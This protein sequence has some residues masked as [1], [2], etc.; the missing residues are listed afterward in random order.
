MAGKIKNLIY[1]IVFTSIL[2]FLKFLII[3]KI[4][5]STSK[6]SEIWFT[7]GLLLIIL[8][9]LITE[10]YFTK[11]LDV[12]VNVI[13]LFIVLLTLD[14]ATKFLLYGP[15]L[16]YASLVATIALI[17]FILVD[18]E[19]DPNVASQKIA[20]SANV[21]SGFLGSSR[22]LFSIVFILSIF[23]YFIISLKNNLLINNEQ[24][25]VLSLI[26]FWGMVIL[27]EPID[28]K[29]INPL[30]EK[31]SNK[32]KP[33]LVGK[34]IKRLNP[35]IIH[36][37]QFPGSPKLKTGDIAAIDDI[38][39]SHV[40]KSVIYSIFISELEADNKKYLQF[41]CLNSMDI[42]IE[43]QS[44]IYKNDAPKEIT[45]LE[46]YKDRDNIIGFI[47]TDSN[48]D[49]IKVRMIDGIDESKKLSEG[50]LISVNFYGNSTKYQ[51]IN[52]ETNSENID[53]QSR[54]G[55]KII[56]AQQI[57]CW[58]KDKQ[59]FV[60]VGWVP[61]VN[62]PVFIE[63][64]TEEIKLTNDSCYKVGVIPRS[65][66]PI[67]IDLEESVSHHIAIIG[68]TGTGKSRMAANILE[69][70]AS[71]GYKVVILEVD[72]KH[73]QSLTTYITKE[74]VEEQNSDTFDIS[75]S[76]KNVIS[77]NWQFSDK[78]MAA[79]TLNLSDIT[80]SIIE[81]IINY[82]IKTEDQKICIAMEEAY[83]FIPESTFGKQDFGQPKVSRISQMVLKCR[84]HNIGFLIITQRTALVTKTILYQ[85]HTIIALQSFDET[86]KTFMG[87]YISQKYLD[88]MSILPRFR[89]I[90]VGKGSSCDK[91]VIVN[92]YNKKLK[93]KE[94]N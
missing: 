26:I 54:E 22:M 62:S 64:S 58:Q 77:I 34:I 57:G 53:G 20:G 33:K 59:T 27:I 94:Q 17:S 52:V 50:D 9:T 39:N 18:Q 71:S 87:A 75:K 44:Y 66:Y 82:Q 51:I 28:R 16:V 15:L 49:V 91:P 70:M 23:S 67:F 37:E 6:D 80:A 47:D 36:V 5:I 85:C 4:F 3:D 81:N 84:K 72:R 79:G 60:D 30:I 11:P 35:N 24:V 74:L 1:L 32:S 8:G 83:D 93:E 45:E 42:N 65:Q 38:K 89:A 76:T 12:I 61:S 43:K 41:Y 63:N 68:K 25:A 29:L 19:K 48:I 10:K 2:I 69:K 92:F 56:T 88:S 14:N 31:I 7:S 46:V 13:T 73:K 55:S 40:G 90:V 78:D 21:I 86:S